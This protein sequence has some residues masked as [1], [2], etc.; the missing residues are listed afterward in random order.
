MSTASS[1]Q[2]VS[3]DSI[4]ASRSQAA[5]RGI[6]T[7]RSARPG[8]PG[9]SCDGSGF[10]E[11]DPEPDL[12]RAPAEPSD[13]SA[14]QARSHAGTRL[15]AAAR[16]VSHTARAKRSNVSPCIAASARRLLCERTLSGSGPIMVGGKS[17]RANGRGTVATIGA[18]FVL[19]RKPDFGSSTWGSSDRAW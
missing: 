6:A 15:S 11:P 17:L 4:V 13:R 16:F 10:L 5:S 1:N 14:F 12:A 18:E 3:T 19:R 9:A 7:A 2:V 8:P